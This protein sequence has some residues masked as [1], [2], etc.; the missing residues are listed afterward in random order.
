MICGQE[1]YAQEMPQDNRLAS[2]DVGNIHISGHSVQNRFSDLTAN[3]DRFSMGESIHKSATDAE[4]GISEAIKAAQEKAL[5]H[6][7]TGQF[8]TSTVTSLIVTPDKQL[9]WGSLGDSPAYLIVRDKSTGDV[10][11]EQVTETGKK[12]IYPKPLMPFMKIVYE[13]VIGSKDLSEMLTDPNK[14]V[15]VLVTSDGASPNFIKQSDDFK[16]RFSQAAELRDIQAM[17]TMLSIGF[18]AQSAKES[19][20]GPLAD[21]ISL[22][23]AKIPSNIEKPI[24]MTVCDASQGN[25]DFS[26]II[27]NE[28]QAQLSPHHAQMGKAIEKETADQGLRPADTPAAPQIASQNRVRKK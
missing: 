28:M 22:V 18:V 10:S 14:E 21:N 17:T 27:C 11:I 4:K 5:L 15:Y 24:T 25:S 16:K 26:D 12:M 9:A 1:M 6:V 20:N 7:A 13:P 19:V 3:D 2:L 8:C 23:L